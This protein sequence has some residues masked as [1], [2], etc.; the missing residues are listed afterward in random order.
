MKKKN[1]I[2][3][4]DADDGYKD[5]DP[6]DPDFPVGKMIRIPD[7]LPPPGELIF[8]GDETEKVTIVLK[9]RNVDFFRKKAKEHHTK[10]QRM[11]REVLDRYVSKYLSS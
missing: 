2:K 6:S 7:F 11:I 10:Y 8:P 4:K 3:D 9:K 5:D 1:K